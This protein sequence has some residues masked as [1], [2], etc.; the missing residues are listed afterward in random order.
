M[1]RP[2]TFEPYIVH[3]KQQCV[4]I[5]TG[6]RPCSDGKI[7]INQK[8]MNEWMNNLSYARKHTCTWTDCIRIHALCPVKEPCNALLARKKKRLDV[9][10]INSHDDPIRYNHVDPAY[11]PRN[12][13]DLMSQN[14]IFQVWYYFRFDEAVILNKQF[15]M[16]VL[17]I[18]L[19]F[20]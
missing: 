4:V 14:C 12:S 16:A 9:D 1:V 3:D 11:L 10:P 15:M 8:K 13:H 19:M 5:S 7:S 20:L 6:S 18:C 17:H 2:N